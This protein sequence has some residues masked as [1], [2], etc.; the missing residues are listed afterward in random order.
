MIAQADNPYRSVG[1][2]AGVSYVEREA[3]VHLVK[4]IQENRFYPYFLAPRQSGKS[5]LIAH[6]I[7]KLEG[8]YRCV[9]I[10]L[11][12]LAHESLENYDQF[13]L[14]FNA[15]LLAAIAS[16]DEI[17]LDSN[18]RRVIE[19]A[20][21]NTPKRI[22]IFVDEVDQLLP[23]KFKDSFFGLIRYFFNQRA[24]QPQFKNIQFVLAGAAS[25]TQLISKE[26]QSP[27][28]V[29]RLIKL[30]DLGLAQVDDM[31]SY[32]RAEGVDAGQAICSAIFQ[33]TRGSVFLTQLVLERVWELCAQRKAEAV[34][35]E[36]VGQ[37][38]DAVVKEAPDN[39]HFLNIYS[40]IAAR[41]DMLQAFR[42]YTSGGTVT[43][44][45]LEYLRIIG[46]T[47]AEDVYRNP[48]YQRVF[49][50]GGPLSL[51]NDARSAIMQAAD[52]GRR[53]LNLSGQELT[54]LPPQL[55][56]LTNLVHL[57]ISNN[58]LD[59]LPTVLWQLKGLK[60]LNL[61]N[62]QL[63]ALPADIRQLTNLKTLDLRNNNLTGIPPEVL[64]LQHLSTLD[65]RDNPL[66]ITP[67]VLSAVDD[68]RRIISHYLQSQ[69]PGQY[70]PLNEAKVLIVGQSS[71]GKTSLAMR[72]SRNS[73]N[74][75]ESKTEGIKITPLYINIDQEWVKLNV[76]DF[77]GQEMMHAT[78]QFFLTKRSLYLLV[79]NARLDEEENRL[80]YWLKLIQSFGGDSPV[81]VVGN[82]I[83]QQPLDLD[84]RGLTAKYR[85]IRAFVETSCLDN[86]GLEELKSTIAREVGTLEHIQDLLPRAWFAVKTR[87]EE[88]EQDYIPYSEY[89]RLCAEEQI[90]DELS[91]RTLIG[92][93]HD[94]GIVLN[95]QDDPR[96]EDTNVLNPEWVTGAVYRIL[97]SFELFQTKGV[98]DRAMLEQILDPRRYPKDKHLFIMDMMRKFELCFDL[99]GARDQR[100]LIPDLLSKEEPFTGD[101]GDS[102]A[103]QYHYNVLPSSIISRFI[104]RMHPLI[105][106]NTLWRT[107]VVL[108]YEKNRALMKA[109]LEDKKVFIRVG[110]PEHTRR[111]LLSIIRS[112]FDSIHK[113]FPGLVA[114]EKVPL[115]ESPSVVVDYKHL[116]TLEELGE[117]T[118][119][120]SGMNE[121]FDVKRL[122]DGVE[123][124]GSRREQRWQRNVVGA[125][126]GAHAEADG[127]ALAALRKIKKSLD[128]SSERYARRIF[129]TW[130]SSLCVAWLA[131]A[132]FIYGLGWPVMEPWTYLLGSGI[133]LVTYLYFAA[134]EREFSPAAIYGQVVERRKRHLYLLNGFD[135]AEY[136]RLEQ[137]AAANSHI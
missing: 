103:F 64:E 28:N 68:P 72:L 29:G 9:F 133:P 119:I 130:F 59:S 3:D 53:T 39:V 17:K 41:R 99:E 45:E 60:Q 5:S 107:G 123:P 90:N 121:R 122:L 20:V 79:I 126:E 101:W 26:N 112:N 135:P 82:K 85:N 31:L 24:Q 19:A 33:N 50:P 97:N 18:L 114:E 42:A 87:L 104:V 52:D 131:L 116:L 21:N 105:H 11:S 91:Q 98:L 111:A 137:S 80:E 108:A 34:S 69:K 89:V 12:T 132:C 78:H 120:P 65:L 62:N 81:V 113:T 2:Y 1:T 10:D 74:N 92:F 75:Y 7:H 32:L 57:D 110:G 58:R 8:E 100:F 94:L 71:V 16:A 47:A 13:L 129:L 96:F 44:A 128:E 43:P 61:A 77:G 22:L 115:P 118:F 73:F 14:S 109:D 25:P 38:V 6:T 66:P 106:H 70:R 124:E 35:V 63:T 54:V 93:L 127:D 84:R 40:G 83:D 88:M 23:V 86:R 49:G 125:S 55:G 36:D 102:L 136:K 15:D 51:F 67:D 117:T 4:E 56:H 46:I 134:T 95:F 48:I 37:I 30:D 76:W 27:F